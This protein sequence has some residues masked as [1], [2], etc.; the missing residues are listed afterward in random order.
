MTDLPHLLLP[1]RQLLQQGN[2][3]AALALLQD[4]LASDAYDGELLILAGLCAVQLQ[5]HAQARQY[6]QRVVQREPANAVAQFNLGVLFRTLGDDGQAELH[7]RQT[8]AVDPGNPLALLNL[9][10]LMSDHRQLDVAE[11]C[12]TQLLQ[13]DPRHVG[14]LTNLAGVYAASDR[15]EEAGALHVRAVAAADDDADVHTNFGVFLADRARYDQAERHH[16]RAIELAPTH[17]AALC[18]LAVM[19]TWQERYDEAEALLRHAIALEPW[20]ADTHTNLGILLDETGQ[21]E[22]AVAVHRQALARTPLS[23]EVLSNLGNALTHAERYPEAYA[24]Y[25]RALELDPTDGRAWSNMAAMLAQQGDAVAAETAFREALKLDPHHA[26]ARLNL[27]YLLLGQGRYAEGWV[28]HEWRS[29]PSMRDRPT[30][31]PVLPFAQWR[32]EALA[33]KTLLIWAEQGFGDEIQFCRFV[34]ALKRMGVARITLVTKTPLKRLLQSL[35]GVD[36]I[37][38]QGDG[39]HR[40]VPHDFWTL[41]MSLPLWTQIPESDF[42]RDVPY[43]AAPPDVLVHWRQRVDKAVGAGPRKPRIGLTWKGNAGNRNDLDRSLPGL[44]TLEPLFEALGDRVEWISVQKGNGEEEAAFAAGFGKLIALGH[45]ISDFADTA[46]VIAQ[47]DLLISVD[48]AAAHVAGAIG[49]AC[50]VLLPKH[51][52]DWRWLERRDDSPWYPQMRLL[53][54]PERRDWNPVIARV[55]FMLQERYG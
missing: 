15:D 46:A 6:W 38:T 11:A 47:L 55:V 31:L 17:V 32:G 22:A 21:H 20:R 36:E 19:L 28:Q 16:R 53:R 39:L 5:D 27:S 3:A 42:A 2:P 10:V 29:D 51:K 50:W 43:L 13:Q 48:T 18:N 40:L 34:P 8:L 4:W 54:Q 44:A 7:Y 30:L 52:T 23:N 37:L 24:C 33:G 26:R 1:A 49:K 41:P 14:A 45:E 25:A 35:A 9:G 12:F